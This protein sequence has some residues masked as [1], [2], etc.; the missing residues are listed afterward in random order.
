MINSTFKVTFGVEF[1]AIFAFHESLLQRRLETTTITATANDDIPKIIKDIPDAT[2][3]AMRQTQYDYSMTRP[4][5][6]GWGLTTPSTYEPGT[7]MQEI[8]YSQFK[9][10]GYRGYGGEPLYIAKTILPDGVAIHDSFETKFTDFEKWHITQD[11]TLVGVSKADLAKQSDLANR[12]IT[13]E[14]LENWDT[15]GIELVSRVLPYTPSSFD[16]ITTHLSLLRGTSD[17]KHLA[18]PT[19]HCGFHVHIGLPPPVDLEPGTAPPTFT[20]PTLQHLAYL[21]VIYEKAIS[22]LH[23]EHRREGSTAALV[24]LQ[25]NL[26][27]F[28]EEPSYDDVDDDIDLDGKWDG[29]WDSSLPPSPLATLPTT[30]TTITT[31]EEPLISLRTARAKIFAPNQTIASLAKLMSG[32][33][34]GR[35]VNWLYVARTNGLART[36]EFRQH[37]GTLDPVAVEWWVGVCVGLV[38][39]AE[40]RG[41]ELGTGEGERALGGEGN[42]VR[43]WSGEIEVQALLEEMKMGQEARVGV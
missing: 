11:R 39:L 29:D 37:A 28:I 22:K 38:R 31:N 43:E 21:L 30:T 4:S 40:V 32:T 41:R 2:R 34:R 19:T 13:T 27:S 23:P 35:I 1:E 8:L 5:Y 12:T 6:M 26:D 9:E 36:L 7:D 14:E 10:F 25:T 20:L 33:S 3:R 15:H 18:F 16:E 24:D 17:S 42:R